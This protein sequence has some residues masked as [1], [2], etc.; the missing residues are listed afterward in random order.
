[1][2]NI[3][4]FLSGL[5]PERIFTRDVNI[6]DSIFKNWEGWQAAFRNFIKIKSRYIILKN[7][8][9]KYLNPVIILNET[10]Y[11]L[12]LLHPPIYR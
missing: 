10:E 3:Y 7:I 8:N 12:H 4:L 5:D 9:M 1:M 2:K 6:L 11:Q